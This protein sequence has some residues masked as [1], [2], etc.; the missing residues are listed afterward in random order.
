MADGEKS[1]VTWWQTIPGILTAVAA[2]LSALAGLLVAL[3]QVG[4]LGN[5]EAT[6]PQSASSFN[7]ASP[8][9]GAVAPTAT[10]RKNAGP[11]LAEPPP[12]GARI[13]IEDPGRQ[14]VLAFPSGTEVTL[15]SSRADG[16][17]KV[18]SAQVDGRNSAKLILKI[19][20][21]LTNT[22][23][24]DLGFGSDSFRLLVDGVPRAPINFLNQLVDAHSAKEGDVLF[25][26]PDTAKRLVLSVKGDGED[27]ADIPMRLNQLP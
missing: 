21:R 16:T 17:Y 24:S 8:A 27:T 9:S 13:T 15:R 26:V 7:E 19:A 1:K 18:L 23:R 20:L 12:L 25:E 10:P 14:Y 22:G 5:K 4:L 6:V 3:H 11:S 2:I